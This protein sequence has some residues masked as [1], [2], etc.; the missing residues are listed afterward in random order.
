MPTILSHTAVPIALAVGFGLRTIPPRLLAAG[1]FACIAP[2]LDVVAFKFGIAYGDSFGHRGAS[3]SL[4]FALLLAALAAGAA[5]L[6]RA[7]RAAAFWFVLVA[8]ASHPL[9]DMVTTGGMGVALFWPYSDHRWFAPWQVVEVAPIAIKRILSSR[10]LAVLHSELQWIWLPA[11]VL[12]LT[13]LLLRTVNRYF[14]SRRKP[15]RQG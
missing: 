13:T 12:A 1:I 2:D 7:T 3:H 14:R 5:P 10:S 4:A 8:A 15:H 6:L 9:L 11:A